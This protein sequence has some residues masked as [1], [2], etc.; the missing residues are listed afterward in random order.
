MSTF[1]DANGQDWVL[2]IKFHHVEKIKRYPISKDGKPFDLLAILEKENLETLMI[3]FEQLINIV[4]VICYEQVKERFDL[5]AYDE[6]NKEDYEMFPE[7]K[8]ESA[9]FKAAR[10]FA[11]QLNGQAIQELS[12]AFEEALLNFYP[13]Q[14]RKDALKK[15]LEKQREL[16]RMQCEEAIRVFDESVPVIQDEIKRQVRETFSDALSGNLPESSESIPTPSA[17][18]S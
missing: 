2:D 4:F 5:A 10:W 16:E 13:N 3:D 8:V 6:A 14:N 7:L 11:Q 12:E 1:K 17:S 18:E 9:M 15:I